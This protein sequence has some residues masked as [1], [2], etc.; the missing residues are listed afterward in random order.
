MITICSA[1]NATGNFVPPMLVLPR[2]KFKNHFIRDGPNGCVGAATSSGW[3]EPEIFLSLLKHF[4]KTVKVNIE[5]PVL[6]LLDNYYSHL[7][8]DVLDY[9]KDNG[10][11]LLSFPPLPHCSHQL[12]RLDR[13]VFGPLKKIWGPEQQTWMRNNPGKTMTIFD[14]PGILKRHGHN[15][16]V[17]GKIIKGFE[18]TGIYP[19]NRNIFTDIEYAPSFVTDRPNPS[20]TVDEETTG[21]N[22]SNQSSNTTGADEIASLPVASTSQDDGHPQKS[23]SGIV[24]YA[25][26]WQVLK[27]FSEKKSKQMEIVVGDGHCLLHAFAMSLEAEKITV[28]SIEDLCSKLKNEIEQHLS[29]YRPFS[30]NE[31]LIEDIDSYIYSNQYNM[32]TADLVLCALCNALMVTAV[33]YEVRGSF[34]IT[35]SRARST[36]NRVKGKGLFNIAWLWSWLPLQCCSGEIITATINECGHRRNFLPSEE[37]MPHPKAPPRK[38][39]LRGRKRRHTAILTDSLERDAI[40]EEEK[41]G[42]ERKKKKVDRLSQKSK[43]MKKVCA[44]DKKVVKEKIQG[45]KAKEKTDRTL[46]S[47]K[48]NLEQSSSVS[49]TFCIICL[50]P[51][52]ES[53]QGEI[54]R[55]CII[56][57]SWAHKCCVTSSIRFKCPNCQQLD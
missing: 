33:I 4:V 52:S 47:S 1:G 37:V 30:S 31:S 28:S 10:V 26:E 15:P 40:Y 8:I 21:T 38:Q 51:Y 9:C 23:N 7:A 27:S 46:R 2:K 55:R 22:P 14:L 41:K 16:A 50:E 57:K 43:K 49:D 42:E 53:A 36:W 19:F 54:W 20:S 11:V 3:M 25:E 13:T 5:H 24:S 56:Y 45:K 29:F 34:V 48:K 35:L 17:S 6:L 12:Q 44:Q 39:N 18:V 32:N